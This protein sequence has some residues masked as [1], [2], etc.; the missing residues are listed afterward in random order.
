VVYS[1]IWDGVLKMAFLLTFTIGPLVVL[2]AVG[3]YDDVKDRGLIIYVVIG[4]LV[5]FFVIYRTLV[6]T[7]A[8]WL[9]G[10]VTLGAPITWSD[11]RRLRRLF[12]L[13]LGMQWIPMDDVR[14]LPREERR[15]ALLAALD[16]VG[17]TRKPMLF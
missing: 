3:M 5:A 14:L 2:S 10:R 11:A 1:S 15:Q 17:K 7:V 16:T 12:Q 9:H 6:S 13:D 8:S 4:V